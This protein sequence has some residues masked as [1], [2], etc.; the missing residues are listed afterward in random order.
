M[1]RR[2]ERSNSALLTDTAGSRSAACRV[3]KRERSYSPVRTALMAAALS[4]LLSACTYVFTREYIAEPM[5]PLSSEEVDQVF[6]AFSD[7]LRIRG[8]PLAYQARPEPGLVRYRIGGTLEGAAARRDYED[9]LE[10]RYEGGSTFRLKLS[11][12]VHH[13]MDF[14][15]EYL[16]GFVANTEKFIHEATLKRVRIRLIPTPART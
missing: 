5:E 11:R 1:I 8:Y 7:Y 14:S 3:A 12:I 15:D 10:L 6:Q 16:A 2:V 4:A 13:Q 9:I